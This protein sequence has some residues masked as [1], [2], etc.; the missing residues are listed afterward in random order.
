MKFYAPEAIRRTL[1]EAGFEGDARESRGNIQV[2]R[3]GKGV[4]V[5][6]GLRREIGYNDKDKQGPSIGRA[7][8]FSSW[9]REESIYKDERKCVFLHYCLY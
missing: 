2:V 8:L 4:Q 9:R 7:L 6:L 5:G 1:T 3:A